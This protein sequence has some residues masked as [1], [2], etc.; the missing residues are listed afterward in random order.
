MAR[1]S[2]R[3]QGELPVQYRDDE[4]TVQYNPLFDHM[5]PLP[6]PQQLPALANIAIDPG[7]FPDWEQQCSTNEA[8]SRRPPPGVVTT[9]PTGAEAKPNASGSLEA[10]P[11]MAYSSRV[12]SPPRETQTPQV[13]PPYASPPYLPR[14]LQDRR[15]PMQYSPQPYGT[16]RHQAY[17]DGRQPGR[18]TYPPPNGP[19]GPN[20][21]LGPGPSHPGDPYYSARRERSPPRESHNGPYTASPQTQYA[22]DRYP[23]NAP[24]YT[25]AYGHSHTHSHTWPG[26]YRG[27]P[28]IITTFEPVDSKA[29][30]IDHGHGAGLENGKIDETQLSVHRLP[31]T[32]NSANPTSPSN[33]P[34]PKLSI[35]NNLLNPSEEGRNT[36]TLPPLSRMGEAG[37]PISSSGRKSPNGEGLPTEDARQLDGLG[38]RVF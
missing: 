19:Y 2:I 21:G 17:Y 26:Q 12:S 4:L 16:D 9:S 30:V 20:A 22:R 15:I 29:G 25:P 32:P 3:Q 13:M 18:S 5:G 24:S 27:P 34:S 36:L 28:E 31:P 14:D 6:G 38:R 35:T 8:Y 10:T 37:S 33:G 11:S 23:E 1:S 7:R